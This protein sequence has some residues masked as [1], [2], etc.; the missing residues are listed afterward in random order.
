MLGFQVWP[1]S[2]VQHPFLAK[3]LL[4]V[5]ATNPARS[6]FLQGYLVVSFLFLTARVQASLAKCLGAGGAQ[7]PSPS[8]EVRLTWQEEWVS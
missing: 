4:G 2:D 8:S 5:V 7:S 6:S 1:R 3:R